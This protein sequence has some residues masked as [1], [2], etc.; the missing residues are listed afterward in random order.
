MRSGLE[1]RIVWYM[2]MNVLVGHS[3][4]VFTGHQKMGVIGPDNILCA[5]QSDYTVP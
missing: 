2:F 4:S 1:C 5:H 3:G